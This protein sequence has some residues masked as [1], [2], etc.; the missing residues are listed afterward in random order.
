MVI[1]FSS[2][3]FNLFRPLCEQLLQRLILFDIQFLVDA[4]CY[5]TNKKYIW[6]GRRNFVFETIAEAAVT[7][8][9]PYE[10]ISQLHKHHYYNKNAVNLTWV[11]DSEYHKGRRSVVIYDGGK[12]Q[13]SV[14]E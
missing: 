12:L 5:L 4:V 14:I 10:Q 9:I 2:S 3:C 8:N 6:Q 7:S 13:S 1:C 11:V